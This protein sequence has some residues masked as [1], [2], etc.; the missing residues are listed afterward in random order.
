[1]HSIHHGIFLRLVVL[2]S[3]SIR[4]LGIALLKTW[5][6]IRGRPS[7]VGYGFILPSTRAG[8]ELRRSLP[9]GRARRQIAHF[10]PGL[11]IN[12]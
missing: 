3:D 2:L 9:P 6:H 4:T 10:R 12:P 11:E 1:M 5:R 8:A 7:L